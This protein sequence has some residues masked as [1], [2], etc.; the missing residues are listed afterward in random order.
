MNRN[1]LDIV[2]LMLISLLSISSA[3][4]A[5]VFP[6]HTARF[7]LG[8]PNIL[9]FPGYALISS[10]WPEKTAS[11]VER[12]VVSVG[13]SIVSSI[14]VAL[15]I[16]SVSGDNDP[17]TV[18]I[19]LCGLTLAGSGMTAVRR[20]RVPEGQRFTVQIRD[21]F[22]FMKALTLREKVISSALLCILVVSVVATYSSFSNPVEGERFTELYILDSS[23][24]TLNYPVILKPGQNA[25]LIIGLFCHENTKTAYT[26]MVGIEGSESVAYCATWDTVFTI[27][28][29]RFICR[30]VT[31]SHGEGF[32]D[33]FIFH[34]SNSGTYNM[35]C[36]I[37]VDGIYMGHEVNIWVTVQ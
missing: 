18:T 2:D 14:V 17:P 36:R 25:S 11:G 35:V 20:M 30:T 26:I 33:E 28:P 1:V 29:G 34:F 13:F 8:V 31:L 19:T 22:K 3:F 5:I 37:L 16:H 15:I 4:V 32:E 9:F 6:D 24:H 7:V 10:I 21:E 12:I 27:T 23:G